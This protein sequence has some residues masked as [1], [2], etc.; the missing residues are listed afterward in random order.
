M[1]A[2]LRLGDQGAEVQGWQ[3]FLRD[4][5]LYRGPV[6]G[7]FGPATG[8][9]TRA[10]QRLHDLRADGV[11]GP[12]TLRT[13]FGGTLGPA[14][15]PPGWLPPKPDFPPVLTTDQ[16][17]Q[18]FGRFE[19][20]PAP[21]PDSPESIRILGDWKAKN[22][23]VVDVPQLSGIPYG[24]GGACDGRVRFHQ[25]AADVL[26]RLFRA[27]DEARLLDRIA[28]FDGAFNARLMRGSATA[29]SAHSFGSAFDLNA[30]WNPLGR[31]PVGLGGKGALVELVAIAN[32]H[33]FYWGGHFQGRPDGM[34]FELAKLG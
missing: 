16:R 6:D 13:A 29:L 8:D 30:S 32:Q 3:A 4:E 24:W 18:M 23:C 22:L 14:E 2:V 28:T 33:G 9:A 11:A 15:K 7:R 19:W 34:H 27:W 25:R 5:A 21:T 20:D 17:A 1:T 26:K 10:F 31:P 12:A